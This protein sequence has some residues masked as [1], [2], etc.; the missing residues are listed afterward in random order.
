MWMAGCFAGMLALGEQVPL[1]FL[2]YGG[3]VAGYLGALWGYR[4]MPLWG[5]VLFGAVFRLILLPAIPSLSDDVYRYAWD[6]KV[7]WFGINPY[8]YA[9]VDDALFHLRDEAVFP[10]INH[11]E[12]PTIYPPVAQVLF[13]IGYALSQNIWGIK[14]LVVLAEGAMVW[15]LVR[16]LRMRGCDARALLIYFWHPLVVAEGAG[17]GHLDAIGATGVMLALFLFLSQRDRM[18][19]VAL[20]GAA[21]IK[22][23]PVAFA[24]FFMRRKSG[25]IPKNAG[26]FALLPLVLIL[27]YV[28]YAYGGA[29]FLGSL[30]VY[31]MHWEFN[32]LAFGVVRALTGDGSIARWILGCGFAGWVMFLFYRETPPMQAVFGAVAAFLVLTPTLH[33]WYALYLVPFLCFFRQP[34]WIGFTLLLGLSYHVLIRHQADGIWEEAL[35]VRGAIFGGLVGVW[36]ISLWRRL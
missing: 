20:G 31:A 7:Q 21:L 35:W 12:L 27:G 11:A 33:P 25:W 13:L 24:L 26:A 9:P 3:A 23:L 34:A 16:L 2:F 17:N 14:I 19:F 22:F 1:F 10:H 8:R 36:L 32:G 15:V 28:P 29:P 6:G 18:A 5:I 4:R 30:G